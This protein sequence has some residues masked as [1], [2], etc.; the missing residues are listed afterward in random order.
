MR[1]KK[2]VF[3]DH[4][5]LAEEDLEA[6]WTCE[7]RATQTGPITTI[8]HG[9]TMPAE[10]A[11]TQW[12]PPPIF[13][14]VST[15]AMAGPAATTTSDMSMARAATVTRAEHEVV[16]CTTA[17]GLL[18][19]LHIREEDAAVGGAVGWTLQATVVRVTCR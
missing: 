11:D 10:E 8:P 17:V 4:R 13:T 14:N 9:N 19:T 15:M 12:V 1:L 7:P 2:P 18:E 6:R 5:Q 16:S 3:A